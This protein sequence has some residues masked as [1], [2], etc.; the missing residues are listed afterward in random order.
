M[1]A[2]SFRTGSKSWTPARRRLGLTGGD[3]LNYDYVSI[4]VGSRVN[5]D[6]IP[7][8]AHDPSVW[9]VKPISNLWKLRE[10]LESRFRAGETPR[11]AV[12]GGG[13][14]GAEVAANLAA[15]ATR[16]AVE[17]RVTLGSP[18]AID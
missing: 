18:Q 12:V 14:T 4:N 15:L 6:A 11:V 10:H 5:A 9:A 13:P 3:D 8:A 7:G 17:P 1:V 16:H 2:S